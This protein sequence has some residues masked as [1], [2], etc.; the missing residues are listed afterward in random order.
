MAGGGA[1][2]DE[3]VP[4]RLLR[5][6]GARLEAFEAIRR[7]QN[8]P[9]FAGSPD[10]AT[11][12]A[13]L[14]GSVYDAVLDPSYLLVAEDPQLVSKHNFITVE[15]SQEVVFGRSRLE[16]SSASPGS[17]FVGGFG[18]FQTAARALRKQIVGPLLE[19]LTDGPDST[20]A[21]ARPVDNSA[22]APN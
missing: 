21:P 11:T 15:N 18:D 9:S 7:M 17:R 3:A 1:D 8:V 12:L 4:E 6:S 2:L 10:G 19:P 5:L 14:S 16:I 22:P 13:A 20:A